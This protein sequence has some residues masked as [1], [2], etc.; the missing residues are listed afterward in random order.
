MLETL[1]IIP[2]RG[3]SKRIPGKNL[4]TLS[5]KP[6]VCYAMEAAL[7]ANGI[8]DLLLSSDHPAILELGNAY[9][10][11][12]HALRRPDALSTDESPAIDYIRHALDYQKQVN[13]RR[14]DR[15]VI[16]Q[17]T[18]PFTLGEDIDSTLAMMDAC[19]TRCAVS[20]REVRHDLHPSK[21]KRLEGNILHALYED[22][23]DSRT[24]Q[25]LKKVYVRNGSVY[26]SSA[27]L[28]ESGRILEDPCAAYVMPA[29][30]SLDIN[31]EMDFAFAEFLIQTR[32]R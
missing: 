29:E 27:D 16:I 21:F 31:D 25:E 28:I 26:A 30:R 20:V 24:A 7:L 5:G 4:R 8:S 1:G 11:R 14:Y 15:V 12:I 2:A 13:G 32:A 23:G 22:E 6:L 19:G 3:G 18:S 10:I 9:G 17:P